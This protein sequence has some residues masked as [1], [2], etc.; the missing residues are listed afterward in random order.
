MTDKITGS[1]VVGELD[2][3]RVIAAATS[4]P[5]FLVRADSEEAVLGKVRRVLKSYQHYRLRCEGYIGISSKSL[6]VTALVSGRR[7]SFEEVLEA[8]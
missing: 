2:D 7:V 6:P 5:Y 1:F 4:A 3:G 8:A